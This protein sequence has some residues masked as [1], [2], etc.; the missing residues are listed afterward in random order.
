[1]E[2]TLSRLR[3]AVVLMK[4]D[5]VRKVAEEVLESGIPPVAAINDGLAAGMLIAGNKFKSKEYFI[6]EI[7]AC[8]KAFYTGLDILRPHLK[9]GKAKEKGEIVIGVVEGDI[10]DIGKNIVKIMLEADGY[11]IH[12]LGR[13]V[14]LSLFIDKAEEVKADVIAISTLM[15]TSM[16]YMGKMINL[17]RESGSRDRVKV[18][19]GGAPVSAG[20][21]RKIGAD[22]YARDAVEAVKEV[23]RLLE[24]RRVHEID[25]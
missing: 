7:L 23:G 10:H 22:G 20:F 5:D 2:K 16:L 4:A 21:A 12:D 24:G 11:R 8:S 3:D 25:S 14:K 6:P 9:P 17:L 18:I 13:D 15:S 19:V 1:M